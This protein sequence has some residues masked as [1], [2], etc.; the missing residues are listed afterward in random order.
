MTKIT[1]RKVLYD[2]KNLLFEWRNIN[3]LVQL[4]F[5]RQKVTLIEHNEWFD[6][7]VNN[8]LFDLR[9]IQLNNK[10][11]GLVRMEGE[12]G[13]CE[14]SIYLIP[15]NQG[16]GFG[17]KA[18]SKAINENTS[19]NTFNANVQIKNNQSQKL[20]LKLNFIEISRDREFIQYQR[21]KKL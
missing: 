11:I 5:L 17:F 3:E 9:I 21:V 16:K 2:D 14:V 8:P 6:Q 12:Q 13:S 20:F 18:L 1:L 10:D 7:R 4:S 19:F 15:G